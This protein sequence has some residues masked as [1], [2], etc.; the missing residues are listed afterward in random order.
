MPCGLAHI[1]NNAAQ[2][3]KAPSGLV[4]ESIY[5]LVVKTCIWL[6]YIRRRRLRAPGPVPIA[7]RLTYVTCDHTRCH[8]SC[9]SICFP[10][11]S[12][13]RIR[14]VAHLAAFLIIKI[15]SFLRDRIRHRPQQLP[16]YCWVEQAP[17]VD[18]QS[19]TITL[20]YHPTNYIRRTGPAMLPS[21]F[22]CW[23]APWLEQI[24][25]RIH[26]IQNLRFSMCRGVA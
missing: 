6:C 16:H 13:K 2:C 9:S 21:F 12:L 24:H 25:V 15:T 11:F 23:S 18:L 7:N 10:C 4:P 22:S 19:M 26:V 20:I 1:I 8:G 5:L 3:W 14:F 17:P